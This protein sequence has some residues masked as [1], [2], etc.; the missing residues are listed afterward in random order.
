M[1]AKTLRLALA[2]SVLIPTLGAAGDGE[3]AGTL[4]FDAI[5]AISEQVPASRLR[6]AAAKPAA[7]ETAGEEDG[8]SAFSFLRKSE[9]PGQTAH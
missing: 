6:T 5:W 1:I 2:A 9:R 7:A 8:L 4:A 3:P